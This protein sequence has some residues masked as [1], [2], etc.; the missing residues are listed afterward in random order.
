MEHS[1]LQERLN[2]FAADYFAG[3]DR[4]SAISA[5]TRLVADLPHEEGARLLNM[6]IAEA[7]R[8]QH[9]E[10]F[11]ETETYRVALKLGLGD[12][13]MRLANQGKQR[14]DIGL[15]LMDELIRQRDERPLDDWDVL[16]AEGG[17]LIMKYSK[18]Q[19][20]NGEE[21]S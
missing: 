4:K 13:A 17:G 8:T 18:A 6:A 14:F 9:R 21:K 1:E 10:A 20:E 12:F 19:G 2:S 16:V 11:C 15:A 5:I 7:F 3:S